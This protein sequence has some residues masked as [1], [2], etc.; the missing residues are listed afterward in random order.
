MDDPLS[1]TAYIHSLDDGTND[2]HYC[3][4]AL[5][6]AFYLFDSTRHFHAMGYFVPPGVVRQTLYLNFLTIADE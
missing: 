3:Q 6:K 5:N 4:P 1:G 2:W